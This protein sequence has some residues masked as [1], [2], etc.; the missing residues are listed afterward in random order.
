MLADSSLLR[1][2]YRVL[3]GQVQGTTPC[4]EPSFEFPEPEITQSK[5][6]IKIN[7]ANGKEVLD[8][9]SGRPEPT[10][11]QTRNIRIRIEGS[12]APRP[13]L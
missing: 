1:L 2:K 7:Y 6:T 8:G 12:E 13:D 11:V 3:D 5:I 4:R 10:E 9:V